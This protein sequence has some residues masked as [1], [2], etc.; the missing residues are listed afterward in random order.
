M[1]VANKIT[2]RDIIEGLQTA[3]KNS[4]AGKRGWIL[5]SDNTSWVNAAKKL[6]SKQAAE[7]QSLKEKYEGSVAGELSTPFNTDAKQK[8]VALSTP[9]DPEEK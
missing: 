4:K 1:K 5:N 3:L 9:I 6:I 7:I 8:E 2:P